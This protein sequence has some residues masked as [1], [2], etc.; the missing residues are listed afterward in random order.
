MTSAYRKIRHKA[1]RTILRAPIVWLRNR[2]L[3]TNDV[4]LASYPRSGNTWLRYLLAQ[5]LT[6]RPATFESINSLIPEVGIHRG[7][8]KLLPG[9]G[10][11]IKTHELYS[12]CYKR[13]IYLIR[14]VR[15]VIVSQFLRE[16]ELGLV[17]W[18]AFDAYIPRFLDGSINNFGPWHNHIPDWLDSPL[19]QQGDLL[20]VRF[21]EMRRNTQQ[22]LERIVDFLGY[23]ASLETL[24]EAIADN[25]VD[26]LRSLENNTQRVHTSRREDGRFIRQGAVMGWRERLTEPQ[27]QLIEKYAG[28]TM[29]RLGYP[30]WK[31]VMLRGNG[32]LT[33]TGA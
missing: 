24:A 19:A 12:P 18:G 14:D 25:T 29:A 4:F 28:K 11:L 23:R 27:L 3:D 32:A 6:G 33:A 15:D 21:E 22:Q 10:R 26:R 7:A 13:A 20:V 30:S 9:T 8:A 16:K 2:G 5:V 17:W 1:S 31:S